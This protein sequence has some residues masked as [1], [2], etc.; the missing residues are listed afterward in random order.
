MKLNRISPFA[1]LLGVRLNAVMAKLKRPAHSKPAG[2]TTTR[3]PSKA[4]TSAHPSSAGS[5]RQAVRA[6]RERCKQIMHAGLAANVPRFAAALAFQTDMTLTTAAKAI[7]EVALENSTRRRMPPA[8][9][10]AATAPSVDGAAL[11]DLQQFFARVD[12]SKADAATPST[13]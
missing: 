10:P 6:E 3:A 5:M 9:P 12:A 2:S 7:S 11:L 8:M 4:G 13:L 1:H